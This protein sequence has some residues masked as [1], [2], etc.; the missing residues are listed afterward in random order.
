MPQAAAAKEVNPMLS[1]R[2]ELDSIFLKMR[3]DRRVIWECKSLNGALK[4]RYALISGCLA[5][6]LTSV[7]GQ[8][9][10]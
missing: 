5:Y 10:T 7:K 6:C 2:F 3:I 4:T 8:Y 9:S 1:C